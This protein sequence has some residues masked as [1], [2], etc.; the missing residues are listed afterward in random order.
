MIELDPRIEEESLI[1]TPFTKDKIKLGENGYFAVDMVM[2][3]DLRKCVYGELMEHFIGS[4]C[5]YCCK[6]DDSVCT[7]AFYIPE[8]RL[9]IEEESRLKIE[10]KKCRPYTFVEFSEKFTIGRPIE[11]RRKNR[12]KNVRCL[13][14]NGC[15][16][17]RYS[18]RTVIYIYIG[19]HAYTLQELFDEYEWQDPDTKDYMPFGVEDDTRS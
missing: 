12:K 17:E 3:R 19:A 11:F 10:E 5:P 2:F 1:C 4:E 8:S 13:I 7:F 16:H 14:L 15:M 6:F 18:D 9:K